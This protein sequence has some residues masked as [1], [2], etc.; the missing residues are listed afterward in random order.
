VACTRLARAARVRAALL[1][2]GIG[3]RL[4]RHLRH[5]LVV[6]VFIPT[7][8][9]PAIALE[10]KGNEALIRQLWPSLLTPLNYPPPQT[11]PWE[12][13]PELADA[14]QHHEQLGR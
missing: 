12:Q 3:E 8:S 13:L 7:S 9:T 4:L 1:D 6:Q 10:R 5:H 2:R 14:F 11:V